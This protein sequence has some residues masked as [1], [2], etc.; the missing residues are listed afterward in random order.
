MMSTNMRIFTEDGVQYRFN[1]VVF[2]SR[3]DYI[4]KENGT[5]KGQVAE[6]LAEKL[7]VTQDAINNWKYGK[8]GPGDLETIKNAASLLH[9]DW[10]L[11]MRKVDGGIEMKQL[12]DR[13]KDAAKRIYDVL[14]W[15]LEEFSNTDGFNNWWLEFHDEG[16]R[17]PE[18]CIY[19]RIEQMEKRIHLVLNQEYFDLH[20][21]EIYDAFCEFAIEDLTNVY[22]EKVSYAY[23]FEA[24]GV[25]ESTVWQDYE[26]AMQK[27]N[28]I[29][30]RYI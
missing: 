9:T 27:L 7:C 15:F 13:Q 28:E 22:N 26:K 19:D 12:N 30:E 2:R 3:I 21:H 11:F 25:N 23:R 10:K 14:V 16:R 18:N 5:T 6:S 1:S 24:D 8:N 17:N 29:V 20:D 4:A